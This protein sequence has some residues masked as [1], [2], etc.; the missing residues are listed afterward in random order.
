MLVKDGIEDR[1]AHRRAMLTDEDLDANARA[2]LHSSGS[3][4]R[5]DAHRDAQQNGHGDARWDV[6]LER[7]GQISFVKHLGQP[8]RPVQGPSYPHPQTEDAHASG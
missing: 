3:D 5:R 8:R 4:A 6:V 1:H 2:T 7:D